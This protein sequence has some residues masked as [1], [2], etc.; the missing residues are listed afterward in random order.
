MN[1]IFAVLSTISLFLLSTDLLATT[2][3]WE[4]LKDLGPG[5]TVTLNWDVSIGGSTLRGT[6][7]VSNPHTD[8]FAPPPSPISANNLA[9]SLASQMNA[10]LVANN[11][12]AIISASQN[13]LVA[14]TAKGVSVRNGTSEESF[15]E[16]SE[17]WLTGQLQILPD[18]NSGLAWLTEDGVFSI[19]LGSAFSSFT[20]ISGTTNTDLAMLLGAEMGLL[21][22]D[23]DVHGNIVDYSTDQLSRIAFQ[24]D[25]DGLEYRLV[26][27][28]PEPGGLALVF[29]GIA[30]VS[31]HVAK[32]RGAMPSMNC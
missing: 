3:G 30:L 17:N 16:F 32:K 7:S 15:K 13:F 8:I 12:T 1:R 6:A 24:F 21:G 29:L 5:K 18:P 9:I 2:F 10:T 31:Y 28:V 25:G 11:Q 26:S 4:V 19:N 22:L 20:A 14:D 23:V 27:S